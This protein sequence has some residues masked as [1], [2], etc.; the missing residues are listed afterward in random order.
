MPVVLRIELIFFALLFMIFVVDKVN[1][2]KLQLQFCVTW[3]LIAIALIVIAIFPQIVYFVASLSGIETSSN[4]V[5][6]IGI[7]SL[8]FILINMTLKVSKQSAE[9]RKLIQANAIKNF[10]E[11]KLGEDK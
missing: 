7:I 2:R 11:E 8:I 1:K 4:L 5:Y 10:L 3:L 9:I 6:L